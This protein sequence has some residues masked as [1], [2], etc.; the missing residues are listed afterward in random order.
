MLI[1]GTE[2]LLRLLRMWSHL[3]MISWL[4][5]LGFGA[6]ACMVYGKRRLGLLERGGALTQLGACSA[7]QKES[8]GLL[9]VDKQP[10]IMGSPV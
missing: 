10:S 8:G 4:R 1:G 6:F 9:L 3:F 5:A 7:K 2:T